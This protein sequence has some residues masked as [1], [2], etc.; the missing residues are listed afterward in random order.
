MK[1]LRFTTTCAIG[2]A[3]AP[4]LYAVTRNRALN[5]RRREG[6]EVSAGAEPAAPASD[7]GPRAEARDAAAQALG[8]R[9]GA[10]RTVPI[11]L[12]VNDLGHPFTVVPLQA[13][14][15]SAAFMLQD[16]PL[17][18]S[19]GFALAAAVFFDAVIVRMTLIP[20][21]MYLMG[22]RAWW[23]PRWLDRL[24]PDVDVEGEK[25]GRPGQTPARETYPGHGGPQGERELVSVGRHRA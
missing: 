6:R 21:L 11:D 4:W 22:D 2:A 3:L 15:V 9:V 5:E 19:I 24:L 14:G 7:P 8:A 16:E 18:Q 1:T 20:A 23:L 12:V 10:A 13:P 25:L 17:I